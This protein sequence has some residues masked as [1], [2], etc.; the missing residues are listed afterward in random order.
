MNIAR[1]IILHICS[2]TDFTVGSDIFQGLLA[3]TN[4]NGVTVSSSG[5][6]E[7][8]TL[9]RR[10]N[11]Y[12]SAMYDDYDTGHDKLTEIFNLLSYSHGITLDSRDYIHEI[13]GLKT[14]GFVTVTEQGKYIFTCSIICSITRS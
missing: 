14:P 9:L 13:V 5:G 10:E 12:L 6:V 7:N 4:A 8:D 3:D 1:E 11:V 2:N